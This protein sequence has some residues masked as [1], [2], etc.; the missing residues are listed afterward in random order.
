MQITFY[1]DP[2]TGQPHIYNHGVDESEVEDILESA[3]FE[4]YGREGTRHVLGQTG[5]GRYLRV[6]YNRDPL[7]GDAHVITAYPLQGK[8]LR[9]FK[10]LRRRKRGRRK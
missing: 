5:G 10:R 2:A 3:E 1:L 6:V 4:G 8:A 7:T 9:A